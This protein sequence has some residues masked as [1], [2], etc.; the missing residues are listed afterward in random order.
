MANQIKIQRF[1][2]NYLCE[3]YQDVDMKFAFVSDAKDGYRQ[4]HTLAKCRDFLQDAIRAF[5]TK[6]S[7]SIYSFTYKHGTN[8]PIDMKKTRMLVKRDGK[9]SNDDF[10][11][12]MG[13]AKRL[14]V[15]YERKA[16]WSESKVLKVEGDPGLRVF[17]SPPEWMRAPHLISLYTLLIRLGAYKASYCGVKKEETIQSKF[18][19]LIEGNRNTGRNG[20]P[21]DINYLSTIYQHIELIMEKCDE[22]VSEKI[23]DN[24]PNVSINSLHN[25]SGIVSLCQGRHCDKKLNEAFQKLMKKEK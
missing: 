3:I 6:G 19:E 8:P 18:K 22:L 12:Q 25:H 1:P 20:Q 11:T 7:A 5:I 17:I 24:Y 10:K 4:C 23:E 13:R 21:L 15:H 9:T 16:G 2:E 14:L